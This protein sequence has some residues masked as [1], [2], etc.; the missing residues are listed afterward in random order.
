MSLKSKE[1]I[2]FA[3]FVRLTIANFDYDGPPKPEQVEPEYVF[4]NV[5]SRSGRP[6][7]PPLKLDL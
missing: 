2:E 6:V 5:I 4:R 7:R 3:K 1:L